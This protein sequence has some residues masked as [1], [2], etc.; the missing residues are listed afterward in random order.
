MRWTRVSGGTACQFQWGF[1]KLMETSNA[2]FIDEMIADP[3]FQGMMLDPEPHHPS[4][5]H[6]HAPGAHH[7]EIDH[8]HDD[9][10][11][12]HSFALG[13]SHD[14]QD[15]IH[16]SNELAQDKVRSTLRSFVRDWAAEGAA[17]R[18]ACYLPCLEAL[19]RHFPAVSLPQTGRHDRDEDGKSRAE[20][21]VLVPGCGLGRLLMEI[22]ARGFS[23]QGN[24][25]STYMLLG[26]NWVLNQW[27]YRA[28][29]LAASAD[30]VRTSHASSHQIHPYLHSFSNHTT[31]SNLLRRI[32]IP[33]VVPSELLDTSSAGDK[34]PDFSLVAGDFEEIYGPKNW[35]Q[36]EHEDKYGPGQSP[37]SDDGRPRPELEDHR[38]QWDAVVTCFFLDCVSVAFCPLP[39]D[40]AHRR[41]RRPIFSAICA[42]STPC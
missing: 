30:G 13:H 5:S 14:R 32:L 8:A 11:D 34:V 35:S 39:S 4:H 16:R 10:P 38:G 29:T 26:S 7:N 33:D 21:R 6:D 22:V 37:H 25:F 19:E 20:R 28:F 36:A 2:E 18:E 24:E 31:T 41:H 3:V 17:E 1:A 42:S 40:T 9:A 12:P 23:A 15:S 27:V